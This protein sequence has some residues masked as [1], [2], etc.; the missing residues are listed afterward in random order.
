MLR[1]VCSLIMV[2]GAA[3]L[4]LVVG[5]RGPRTNARTLWVD[6]DGTVGAAAASCDGPD[7]AYIRIQAAI[8][9]AEDGDEIRICPGVYREQITIRRN[10]LTVRSVD[11]SAVDASP[12]TIL[13][14]EELDPAGVWILGDGNVLEGLVIQ[15]T[16]AGPPHPGHLHQLIRVGGDRNTVRRNR[17]IG[18]GPAGPADIGIEVHGGDVGNGVAERNEI[19]ENEILNVFGHALRVQSL[20]R[21]RAAYW[22]VVTG[23][24]IHDNPGNGIT[25]DRS[26]ATRVERNVLSRN[27]VA[28][29]FHSEPSFPA[30]ETMFRC[31]QVVGNRAGARN[32]AT[33]GS[34]MRAEYNWWGNEDGPRHDLRNSGGGGDAVGDNV[35]FR[36]WLTAPPEGTCPLLRV[37]IDVMP[38]DASNRIRPA[39]H[40]LIPVALLSG[41]SFAPL[42]EVDRDRL[43]LGAAGGE[44]PVV[45]CNSLAGDLNGDGI[46]DLVCYFRS[47]LTGL[48]PDHRVARLQGQTLEGIAIEG[49][50]AVEILP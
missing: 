43:R 11:G 19:V 39:S 2:V 18:R 20:A 26:P 29:V 30:I 44:S 9:A 21:D 13:L 14:P 8:E 37:R 36:P 31:N 7:P 5:S 34:V 27:G 25:V 23:N 1:T 47:E 46:G 33:D 6:D 40:T 50:D 22:T 16:A 3:Y 10:Y 4:I 48:G 35:A 12:D 41:P 24:R 28:L 42:D 15:D 17:L 45:G 49:Q 38:G 32:T